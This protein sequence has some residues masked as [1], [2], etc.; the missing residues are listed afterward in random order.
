MI[1][2][3]NLSLNQLL[4]LGFSRIQTH[5]AR[6][7]HKELLNIHIRLPAIMLAERL[8]KH[9][10]ADPGNQGHLDSLQQAS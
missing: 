5:T 9:I 7:S 8:I 4:M 10:G 1:E 6:P 3:I 2:G